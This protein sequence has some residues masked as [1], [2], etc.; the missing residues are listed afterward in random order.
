MKSNMWRKRANQK[1]YTTYITSRPH[2]C[3][4]CAEDT[5]KRQLVSQ[6]EHLWVLQSAYPYD[7]W[8]LQNVEDHMLVVPKRHTESL[9]NFTREEGQ[10]FFSIVADYEGRGYSIY[11]R[12]NGNNAKS[13]PHLHTHM[14]KLGKKPADLYVYS[15]KLN[16]MYFK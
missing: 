4:F 8:D 13:I 7:T 12:A 14:F 16:L 11:S 3:D 15:R 1:A 9:S 10:E 2:D 5:I 6:T